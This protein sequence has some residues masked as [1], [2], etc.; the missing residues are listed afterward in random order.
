[1]K[2]KKNESVNRPLTPQEE[3]LAKEKERAKNNKLKNKPILVMTY[4]IV[5][6]FVAMI[7]YVIYFMQFKSETIIANSRNIRQDTFADEVER[8]DIITSDGVVIATSTTDDEGNT[9]REY[10]YANMFAHVVGY[11]DYGKSGLELLG[12]FYMLR[13]HINIFEKVYR[14]LSEEKNRGDN[15]VTTINYELQSV[16]YDAMGPCDGAVIVIEP[17]TGKI[18]TM[19]SKPDFDPNDID[20]VWT[21]LQTEE[22]QD[23]TILLNRATQGLYAPGSTFKVITLLEYI[24]EN[25]NYSNYSY[26]CSGSEIF[27]GVDIHCNDDTWHGTES[28]KDS[29][30]YSCNVSFANIGTLIDYASYGETAESLLF[31]SKLPYDGEYSVSQ[32]EIDANSTADELPQ[33]VIGQGDTRIT[34]LHNAMIMC[35]IANGGVLMEPYL[36]QSVENDDG[37]TIKKFKSRSYGKLLESDEAA[38]LTEYMQSVADYGTA[39]PYF[40]GRS[41]DVAGKTGTA[42]YD[43]EGNC[44]SWFAGFS[45]PDNPDIVVC[46]ITEDYNTYGISA[47]WVAQQI[48]DAYYN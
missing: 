10:P 30:A 35:A 40:S 9:Q 41:Y 42:E 45:N 11:D 39:A 15:I 31:N 48:F 43:D 2:K 32:F 44:N 37:A 17:D 3:F 12:N 14:E 38:I 47:T 13:S 33:T 18:L 26:E 23:S 22:G 8:G 36:I 21:Y 24:R 4:L 7:G 34:P 29:L 20:N 6:V 28:L 27:S 16:A 5:A 25:S 46:V 1:M 19:I